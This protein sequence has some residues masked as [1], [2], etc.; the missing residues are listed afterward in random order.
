M[1]GNAIEMV[2]D[3]SGPYPRVIAE[4]PRGPSEGDR[5][6]M[7]GGSLRDGPAP[8]HG[9]HTMWGPELCMYHIGFR[10]VCEID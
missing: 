9:R 3:L 4:D 6:V 5:W 10:V 8:S 1:V 7:R 2:Q